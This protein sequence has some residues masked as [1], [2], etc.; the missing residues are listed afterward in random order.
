MEINDI[1]KT[2]TEREGYSQKRAILLANECQNLSVELLPLLDSWLQ[3]AEN[4]GDFNIQGYGL[5]NMIQ[6]RGMNYM[7]ALLD[8]DWLIKE[9]EVAKPVIAS[10][11][12]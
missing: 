11:M 4:K 1:I 9:P 5:L 2:L 6:H 3:D 7:A 8:V 10:F 12:K